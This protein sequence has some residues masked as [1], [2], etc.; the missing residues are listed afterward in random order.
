MLQTPA[1]TH[2]ILSTYGDVCYKKLDQNFPNSTPEKH[3]PLNFVINEVIG[4][5]VKHGVQ[6]NAQQILRPTCVFKMLLVLLL[7]L[8]LCWAN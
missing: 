6:N 3:L 8:L 7:L 5:T 1:Q 2:Y 4:N